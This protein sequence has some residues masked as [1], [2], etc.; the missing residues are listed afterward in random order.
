MISQRVSKVFPLFKMVFPLGEIIFPTGRMT[1]PLYFLLFQG[2]FVRST[3][4]F[5]GFRTKL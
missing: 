3:D 5:R 4:T 1:K 2:R